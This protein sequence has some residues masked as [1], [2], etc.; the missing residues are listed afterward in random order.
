MYSGFVLAAADLGSTPG[1][2]PFTACHSPSLSPCFMVVKIN[3]AMKGQ[4]KDPI[5][6]NFQEILL[7]NLILSVYEYV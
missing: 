3:K 2:G 7:G 5:S 1:L 6:E 4:K